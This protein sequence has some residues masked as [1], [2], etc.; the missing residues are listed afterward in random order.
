MPVCCVDLSNG[1]YR[2]TVYINWADIR[3]GAND[4]DIWLRKS[5]DQGNTWSARKRV[6]DDPPG[7]EQFLT[8]MCI[9]N[10]TGYIYIV[11]NDRRNYSDNE[12]DVYLAASTDGG[13]TFVNIRLDQNPFT[14]SSSIFFGDY[15]NISAY[16]NI[17]RPVWEDENGS[18]GAKTIYTALIDSLFANPITWT[19]STSTDW[20]NPWN[21]TPWSVPIST[22]N[23][24][25]PQ[26]ASGH[27]PNVNVT[28]MSCNNLT[29]NANA[30]VT[31]PASMTFDIKGNLTINSGGS[32]TNNG[33]LT[34]RGNMINLN[35]P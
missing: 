27:Y 32:L 33:T 28:G 17:V 23:V 22:Q 10:V 34:L 14:P 9:D 30:T 19:G 2:G 20:N 24:I 31:L 15:T 1:P 26:V 13:Q 21:W 18:S 8:W 4:A 25:V 12:T 29:I 11:F 6:N 7:K 5:T 16:N 3:N 35:N